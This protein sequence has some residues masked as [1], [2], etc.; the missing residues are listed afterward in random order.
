MKLVHSSGSL[1]HLSY[2]SNIHAGE[3]WQAVRENL[4]RYI[5]GIRDALVPGEEFG[6]GLRLSAAAVNDLAQAE[7]LQEFRQF[8]AQ[9]NLYVFTINGFPYGPFHG[10]RVKEDVYLPDWMDEERLRYTNQLADVFASILPDEQNGSISTVPGAFKER[11]AGSDDIRQ[12]ADNMVR[13][14]A[15]LAQLHQNTGKFITL[16]LEPEPCCFL[17]TID[18]S[19]HFFSQELFGDASTDLMA[20]LT[21]TDVDSA[22][23][24]LRKHLTLCLDLC[25]AAVEFE[26]PD[27][28]LAKLEA[29]G[30]TVGKLQISSGLRLK[31][32]SASTVDS[33]EPFIDKVYLH[34]V[35][36]RH[37]GTLNRFTDLPEAIEHLGNSQESREWRVHFHVPIFL[38]EL[39]DFS[40]TQSFVAAMLSRHKKKPISD[41]LEVETYTWDVLPAELRT[42]SVDQAIVREMRWVLEA[43]S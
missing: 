32:V 23:E 1:S 18:E 33:L 36:E 42:Q 3:S 24:L 9:N 35:V 17:E 15:H 38:E 25:H 4:Q 34:Q 16:A 22:R 21:H 19:V 6:I 26:D 7:A 2:C 10:T 20:S 12:M 27:E 43:L 40:S 37:N 30:I 31:D 13:H 28:C 41:H 29:A 8:L 11:V 14:A 39:A 5:P